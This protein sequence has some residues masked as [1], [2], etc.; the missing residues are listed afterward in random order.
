V[1]VQVGEGRRGRHRP[2][3]YLGESDGSDGLLGPRHQRSTG[4]RG[5]ARAPVTLTACHPAVVLERRGERRG[6]RT[7]GGG[8][9]GTIRTGRTLATSLI[10]LQGPR[11]EM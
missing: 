8:H 1:D 4:D 3:F 5:H 9:A 10:W 7:V 6:D 11:A 2:A